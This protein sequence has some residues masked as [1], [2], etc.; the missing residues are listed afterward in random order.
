MLDTRESGD[1]SERPS[2]K[3]EDKR[4]WARKQTEETA[5]EGGTEEAPSLRPTVVDEY[6]LRAEAAEKKLHEYI[7]AFKQAQAE[8]EEF[9]AR[10]LRDVDRRVELKFGGLVDEL[11][12]AADDLDLALSHARGVPGAEALARGVELARDR[13][14]AT[15]ERHGVERLALDGTEFDPNVAEA[16]QLVDASEPDADGKVAATLRSGYRLGDRVIRPARVAVARHR[17]AS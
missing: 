2:V 17:P 6:R 3:V 11:L 10:L 1:G 5:E 4:H 12:E 7:G 14:L 9:R 13:F 15:L 8:Q 16:V